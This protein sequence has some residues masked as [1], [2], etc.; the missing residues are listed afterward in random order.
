V[1]SVAGLKVGDTVEVR[2]SLLAD[3][4]VAAAEVKVQRN[5]LPPPPP[6][7]AAPPVANAGANQTVASGA[8]VTLDGSASA[9]PTGIAVSFHWSQTAG[10][11]VTLSSA[12][13]AQP[14]FTAPTVAFDQPAAALTFSLVVSDANG[15][16][17]P[18]NVSVTVN[19]QPPPPPPPPPAPPV[20]DAGPDQAVAS[21]AFV[22]LDGSA[23]SDP[24]GLPLTFNWTQTAGTIVTLSSNASLTPTFTAPIVKFNQPAAVLTFSLVVSD[25]N[26]SS[27]AA[28]V[29][30]TVSPEA[31]PPAP[32]A[33]AGFDQAVASG[34]SVT[35]DGSASSGPAGL[36][37]SFAWT[38]SS[39]AAVVLT[40]ADTATPSFTA[41]VVPAGT[42]A[43]TLTFSLVVSDKNFS[44]APAS[45]T[46]TVNPEAQNFPPPP[47]TPPPA[48]PNPA[49]LPI[50]GNGSNRFEGGSRT[51]STWDPTLASRRCR[52]RRRHPR[53]AGGSLPGNA[54]ADAVVTM[55]GVPLLRDPNLNGNF[56]RLDP[57][58]PQP[59]IG[60]GGQMVVVA[61]GTDP[62]TGKAI[63]RQLVM[64]CPND[65]SVTSTP[66]IGASL[67]GSPSVTI[68]STSDITFNVGVP[69]V[70]SIFPQATLIGYNR[71]AG[72]LAPSGGPHNIGPGPLSITVPVT[73][74]AA[75]AYL[76]DL[77]WPGVFILDGQTGGFCGLAKRWT[78]TK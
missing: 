8:L 55:N 28:N 49:P 19:P 66:D 13:V 52:I 15:T 27:A 10:P 61:T 1:T 7:P 16:S 31:P 48:P 24:A 32:I 57:A 44:S 4:S 30:V 59:V 50:G 34:A 29:N 64:D 17:A 63:Q 78:Y 72:T 21:G 22:T 47:G 14:T 62:K 54:P 51:A 73:P 3:G 76:L 67:A 69:I 11:V 68:T 9:D 58:G 45:V 74:T 5:A 56:F 18:S 40:G 46:V 53:C 75:D 37:L 6:P 12:T 42:P 39:G 2:G 36:P 38:Q 35:L 60:S 20:A 43:A 25:A 71:A 70:A 23:S 33:N 77:R 41:P 65:I 26:A